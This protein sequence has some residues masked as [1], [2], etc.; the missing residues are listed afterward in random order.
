M[1]FSKQKTMNRITLMF[2]T[3]G[4]LITQNVSAQTTKKEL[5]PCADIG[6]GYLPK[7]SI[8]ALRVSVAFNNLVFDRFGAYTALETNSGNNYFTHVIGLTGSINHFSYVYA[9][10]D[11]FSD[12]GFLNNVGFKDVRKDM[13]IGFYP[14]KWATAKLGYSFSVGIYGEVGVRIPLK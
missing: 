2:I 4:F 1:G 8:Q 5:V 13:G 3:L 10:V 7:S 12:R 14:V 9:G 6:V 11:F